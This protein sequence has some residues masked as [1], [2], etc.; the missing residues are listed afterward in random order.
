MK[1]LKWG[2]HPDIIIRYNDEGCPIRS[3]HPL[4]SIRCAMFNK[5]IADDHKN[6]WRIANSQYGNMIL[7]IPR[8][9]FKKRR[10]YY[11]QRPNQPKPAA[12]EKACDI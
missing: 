1:R 7:V 6:Y 9:G 4:E 10:R 12:L 11:V 3:M 2:S 5:N 8:N